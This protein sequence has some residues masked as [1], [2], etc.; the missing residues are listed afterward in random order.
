MLLSCGDISKIHESCL[1]LCKFIA[2][3]IPLATIVPWYNRCNKLSLIHHR[4]H[5]PP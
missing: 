1:D 5:G 3:V 2:V 4:Q